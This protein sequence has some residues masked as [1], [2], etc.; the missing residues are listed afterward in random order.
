M[1]FFW[2]LPCQTTK[3]NPSSCGFLCQIDPLDDILNE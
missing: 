3:K 1:A 2:R